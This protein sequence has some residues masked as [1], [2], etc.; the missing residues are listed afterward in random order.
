M[1]KMPIRKHQGTMNRRIRRRITNSRRQIPTNNANMFL[2]P[3]TPLAP[4]RIT[5]DPFAN[6][7]FN[8]ISFR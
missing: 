2:I 8:G 3:A 1:N 5:N 6:Q 7:L 4:L